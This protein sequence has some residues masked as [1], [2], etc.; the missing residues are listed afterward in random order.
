MAE[1]QVKAALRLV[2]YIPLEMRMKGK[3]MRYAIDV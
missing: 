1:T 3:L 2:L